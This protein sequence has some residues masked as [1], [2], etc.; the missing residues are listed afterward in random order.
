MFAKRAL[1][2]LATNQDHLA[3]L[4]SS[5]EIDVL[6]KAIQCLMTCRNFLAY[7]YVVAWRFVGGSTEAKAVFESHQSTLEVMTEKLNKLTETNLEELLSSRGESYFRAHFTAL[8][9][10]SCAS[11]MYVER[12]MG[13]IRK[14][15][16]NAT[17]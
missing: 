17:S 13:F 15:R 9:F 7:S 1:D 14:M 8:D 3:Q 2:S 10:H 11:G 12:M 4:L 5:D 6:R 16:L